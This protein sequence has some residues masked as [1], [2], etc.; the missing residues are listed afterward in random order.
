MHKRKLT[1]A[2]PRRTPKYAAKP[3][4]ALLAVAM[5]LPGGTA[6]G[7]LVTSRPAIHC[8]LSNLGGGP[9]RE[10]MPLTSASRIGDVL[11]ERGAGLFNTFQL[12]ATGSAGIQHE[13]AAAAQ[14]SANQGVAADGTAQTNVSGIGLQVSAIGA[15]GVERQLRPSPFPVVMDK[16]PVYF[17]TSGPEAQE[18]T[19]VTEYI[20]RLV[21]TDSP[22]N[23]P[24]GELLVTGVAPNITLTLYTVDYQQGMVNYGD[25]IMDF[26]AW[27][28]AI[29]GV[30]GNQPFDFQGTGVIGLGGGTGVVVPNK[31]EVGAYR[32][33]PVSLGEAVVASLDEAVR[34]GTQDLGAHQVGPHQP[35]YGVVEAVG[36][37]IPMAGRVPDQATVNANQAAHAAQLVARYRSQYRGVRDATSDG[38]GVRREILVLARQAA[39]SN[40]PG[41]CYD[42][43]PNGALNNLATRIGAHQSAHHIAVEPA[44]QDEDLVS[45]YILDPTEVPPNE[46]AYRDGLQAAGRGGDLYRLQFEVD[47]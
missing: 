22:A 47:D 27:S 44:A 7:E 23:L 18:N 21:L 25:Y 46:R 37:R 26:P 14:W 38:A 33:I 36:L 3:I 12:G 17:D 24:S 5:T 20:Q 1:D 8:S 35:A 41:P 39:N 31:C 42:E 4:L 28:P 40:R 29:P 34:G 6:R 16:R 30:C 43:A 13:L 19:T 45:R 10:V 11:F 32:T 2:R 9:W 15:D